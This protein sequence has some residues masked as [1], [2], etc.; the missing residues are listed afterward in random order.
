MSCTTRVAL[1]TFSKVEHG[2]I[3]IDH[4]CFHICCVT[5]TSPPAKDAGDQHF[6]KDDRNL[7]ETPVRQFVGQ[8]TAAN[9]ASLPERIKAFIKDKQYPLHIGAQ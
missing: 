5:A 4:R 6:I 9:A 3:R 1:T 2:T 7:A 8:F